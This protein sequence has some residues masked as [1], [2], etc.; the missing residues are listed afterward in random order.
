MIHS[1]LLSGGS[2]GRLTK[3]DS[4]VEM[5]FRRGVVSAE[6]FLPSEALSP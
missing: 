5:E 6:A 1:F 3:G 4:L 2:Q